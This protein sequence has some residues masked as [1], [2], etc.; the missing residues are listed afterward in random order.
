MEA[1]KIWNG[2]LSS[3]LSFIC[4]GIDI[5]IGKIRDRI[6]TWLFVSNIKKAGRGIK[7][8]YGLEYRYPDVITIGDN[9]IIGRN[10]SITSEVGAGHYLSILSNASI[11]MNCVIDFTGGI[12][13]NEWAHIAHDVMISTHDHGYD[14]RDEPMGKSLEIGENAFIGSRAIIM[15]S[16]N[17]IGKNA[18]IGTGAVVT[19]DVPDRAVVVGSPARIIKYI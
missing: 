7:I 18:V 15:S 14:Y 17:Y 13:I 12:K 1:N 8:C 10:T 16:C 2:H 4:M 6:T 5:L 9:V 11:G 3:I 19:K